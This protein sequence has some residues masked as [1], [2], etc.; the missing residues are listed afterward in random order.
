MWP[1]AE[2]KSFKKITSSVRFRALLQ[3]WGASEGPG[4]YLEASP[5]SELAK[6]LSDIVFFINKYKFEGVHLWESLST[7]SLR[8][9]LAINE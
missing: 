5:D 1:H 3:S 2:S 9:P 4:L 7:S 6:L 8:Y